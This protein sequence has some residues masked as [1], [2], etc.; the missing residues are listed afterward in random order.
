MADLMWSRDQ[1]A[2][3]RHRARDLKGGSLNTPSGEVLVSLH[4]NGFAL[5]GNWSSFGL[6]LDQLE[7]EAGAALRRAE[8]SFKHSKQKSTSTVAT[9]SSFEPLPALRPL[10][11]NAEL[12]R[13]IKGYLGGPVRYD[14]HKL[15][16]LTNNATEENYLSSTWHH[17]RCGRR[18][19]LFIFLQDVY[20]GGRPTLVAKESHNTLYYAYGNPWAL[21]SR[22]SDPWVRSRYH[23]EPMH[24]PRG[25]GFMFDTNALHKGE[26]RG[27]RSRLTVILEFHGHG[28][29]P[30]LA[31]FNNPC[32]SSKALP[33]HARALQGLHWEKGAPTFNEYPVEMPQVGL[34]RED[35]FGIRKSNYRR[36][37]HMENTTRLKALST[38]RG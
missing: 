27:Q 28:K 31:K 14:G 16:L 24:G 10:L 36:I 12:A 1:P 15:M 30:K 8:F 38:P 37:N 34:G 19:K 18:L 32:P 21:L 3:R 13:A 4:D 29:V 17:D 25:G 2:R 35:A 20:A 33:A 11:D 5:V 26:A 9:T 23:V 22:Y 6:N 7:S